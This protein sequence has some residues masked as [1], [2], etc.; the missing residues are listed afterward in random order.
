MD[1]SAAAELFRSAQ[2]TNWC[3]C[4]GCI[5]QIRLVHKNLGLCLRNL[6]QLPRCWLPY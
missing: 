6:W 5:M 2:V 3:C 1:S 4:G